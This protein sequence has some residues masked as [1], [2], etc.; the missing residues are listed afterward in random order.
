M[1]LIA[2]LSSY[3]GSLLPAQTTSTAHTRHA[4]ALGGA[5]SLLALKTAVDRAAC[6]YRFFYGPTAN[7]HDWLRIAR[8]LEAAYRLFSSRGWV[9]RP[10]TYHELPPPL[11]EARMVESRSRGRRYLAMSFESGYTPHAHE[12]GAQRWSSYAANH[13]AHAWVVRHSRGRRPWL[14][15]IHGYGMGYP[16]LDF[17][18]FPVRWLHEELGFNLVLPVLPLHGPRK[19]GRMSGERFLDSDPLDTIH[20]E[21]QAMWDIR[22]ILSWVRDQDPQSVGVYGLSLGGYSAALLAGLERRLACVIAGIPATDFL[23]LA[24]LHNRRSALRCAEEAGLTWS[25]V[26]EVLR[27]ISPL[28]VAPCVGRDRLFM[29][30]GIGDQI[31]PAD[32]ATTLWNHW[33]RPRIE[34]YRGSHF[35]F[36]WEPEPRLLLR[37]ALSSTMMLDSGY[38]RRD[39]MAAA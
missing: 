9:E 30:A 22:R 3:L 13:T 32:H 37:E 7:R 29:F 36:L 8:E 25:R 27:V 2:Q 11:R 18:A 26:A 4:G 35:T 16:M 14:V 28:A 23:R 33:N 38:E 34:W 1:T 15:C 6:A 20:A 10:Q 12:P 5:V 17:G 31:V 19:I 39:D 24:L 21:A